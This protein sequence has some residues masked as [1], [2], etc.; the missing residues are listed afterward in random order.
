MIPNLAKR[1]GSSLVVVGTR[2]TSPPLAPFKLWRRLS[3]QVIIPWTP[4]LPH[5]SAWLVP[6]T[7]ALVSKFCTGMSSALDNNY[8]AV[9]FL[10]ERLLMQLK[11]I[12]H[13]FYRCSWCTI[14]FWL[15]AERYT[16]RLLCFR[17]ENCLLVVNTPHQVEWIW[18]LASYTK[19]RPGPLLTCL[20][21]P[22]SSG[23]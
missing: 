3:R 5:S 9:A 1:A 19:C 23:A 7:T 12:T 18:T 14:M 4:L 17:P 10:V 8:P 15:L 20:V 21:F 16:V 22:G 6:I 2:F 11:S 13:R